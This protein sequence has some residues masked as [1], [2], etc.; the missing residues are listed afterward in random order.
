MSECSALGI[1]SPRDDLVNTRELDD[2]NDDDVGE[3][4]DHHHPDPG[5]QHSALSTLGTIW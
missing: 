1:V 2:D 3:D 5:W 4:D